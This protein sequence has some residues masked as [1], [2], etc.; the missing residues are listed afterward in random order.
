MMTSSD[1]PDGDATDQGVAESDGDAND[2][3]DASGDDSA[4]TEDAGDDDS[5]DSSDQAK[6]DSSDD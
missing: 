1:A 2:A 5:A 6:D 3:E 4:D